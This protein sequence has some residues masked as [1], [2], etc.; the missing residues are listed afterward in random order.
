MLIVGYDDKKGAVLIRNSWGLEWGRFGHSWVSYDLLQKI[1][2]Q[3]GETNF[4]SSAWVATDE[5]QKH[6]AGTDATVR[7]VA[8]VGY[9]GR[10]DG[11]SRW[12][13]RL[14]LA[15]FPE[16]LRAVKK[17]T[18]ILSEHFR[19]RTSER[20]AGTGLSPRFTTYVGVRTPGEHE[21]GAV[22]EHADGRTTKH[23]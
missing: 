6:T 22:V 4:L 19:P 9:V 17:V 3:K 23:K 18:W 7:I 8:S 5:L 15:G 14:Q 13:M 20:E 12:R 2:N 16:A 11:A 10:V 1:G 21:V